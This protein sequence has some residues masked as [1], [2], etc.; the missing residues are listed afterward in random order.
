MLDINQLQLSPLD[1]KGLNTLVSWAQKEGWNPGPY[2]AQ[3]FWNADPN[4]YYGYYHNDELIGGGSIVSYDGKFGFMGFFIVDEPHRSQ[5]IGRQLWKQRRDKLLSR[6]HPGATIGMDG[7]VDMQA[8]YEKGGFKIAFR[9]LRFERKGQTFPIHSNITAIDD[10]DFSEISTYDNQCFGFPRPSFLL[11]WL[12]LPENHSF[13]YVENGQLKGMAIIRKANIGYK[14]G[15]LFA[16]SYSIAEE[17]YKACLN[18]VPEQMVYLDI[19]MSNSNALHLV[20]SFEASYVFECARMYYQ[21]IPT[22]PWHKVYGITSFE[23]G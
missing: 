14:I 17:L 6:I 19:P 12:K 10:G 4:G 18:A 2:D 15:P 1:Q 21:K 16:D 8:F 7:V 13:K 23:L 20:E 22:M 5:G 3:A 9:D 11:P